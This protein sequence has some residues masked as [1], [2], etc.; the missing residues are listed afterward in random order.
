MSW[1]FIGHLF[2]QKAVANDILADLDESVTAWIDYLRDR[3][4]TEEVDDFMLLL[5]R[6]REIAD[7][8]RSD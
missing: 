2:A 4:S 6:V 3:M 1:P 5:S 7:S 8:Y